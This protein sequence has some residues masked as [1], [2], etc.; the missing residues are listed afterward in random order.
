MFI[1]VPINEL[2]YGIVS[3]NILDNLS[4]YILKPIGPFDQEEYSRYLPKVIN[5]FDKLDL[6]QPSLRIFHENQ[7]FDHVGKGTRIGFPIFERN[8]FTPEH[9]FNLIHQDI[10]LVCSNWAKQIVEPINPN[11]IVCPLGVD[12]D[13]TPGYFPNKEDKVIFYTQG[14]R[15]IR[16]GHDYLHKVFHKAFS[17]YNDVELWMFTNNYFDSL[18]KTREFQTSYKILLNN[19]VKFFPRLPKKEMI[20][21]LHKTDCGIFLSRAEGW[22]MPLTES[23]AMGKE[24]VATYYSGH[25]EYLKDGIRPIKMQEAFDLPWFYGGFTWMEIEAN[26]EEIVNSL[27]EKYEVCKERKTNFDNV[28]LIK[29]FTWKN[30]AEIINGLQRM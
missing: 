6:S 10:V 3:Q 21:W 8:T 13:F 9:I 7:L 29:N 18:E 26:E 24:V 1:S 28:N 11:V 19:K 17:E 25:T 5:Y 2:S 22:N 14:K 27:R 20:N 30:T 12:S 15:E 4:D 23:L 16:K